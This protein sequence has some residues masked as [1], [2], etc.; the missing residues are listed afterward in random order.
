MP[1]PEP[2]DFDLA[3]QD[4]DRRVAATAP[5][6]WMGAEP[7]YTD[8]RSEAAE[9]LRLADGGDKAARALAM[10]AR[11]AGDSGPAL[12]LRTVGRQYPGEDL[13]RWSFGLYA[14]RDGTPVSAGPPD[15][16]LGGTA[17]S[18]EAL[19]D[20][21]ARLTAELA[22]RG[23]AA[24]SCRCEEV[25]ECRVAFRTDGQP[26]ADLGA[27]P[28]LARPSIHGRAI[29]D[30]GL[31]D[32]LSA[33]GIHLISVGTEPSAT[34]G[35][36]A[37]PRLELPAFATVD[38]FL[39]CLDAIGRAAAGAGLTGLVVAGFPPPVDER[40]AFAT[41]TPDPA[42]VEVNM[43]P[44]ADAAEF[45]AQVRAI[46]RAAAAEGLS[47]VRF[48]YN[49]DVT[50]SGG[51][52]QI[53]FGGPTPETSPFF[54][55]PR[56]LPSLI[57]YCNRHPALSY[58]FT[59][60]CVGSTS[61]SPRPDE[62]YREAFDE[63]RLAL[64]LL[65]LEEDPAPETLWKALA[66]FLTDVAG[67]SHRS[68]INVE[69]LWNPYLLGRGRL[70]LVELRSFRMAPT[71]EALAARAALFRAVVARLAA[72]PDGGEL[73]DWGTELHQRFALPFYLRQ[74]LREVLA[75]LETSGLGLG[76]P[77]VERLLDDG[78]RVLGEAAL[79]DFRLTL[80]R[81]L[82]FWPLAGDAA[83]TTRAAS[84]LIDSST[85]RV[86]AVLRPLDSAAAAA[87]DHWRVGAAGW[88]VPVRRDLDADGQALV[89]SLR[90]RSFI[91][92]QG[93]HPTLGVQTPVEL[94]LHHAGTGAAYRV[95]LHEWK[96]EGGGYE[97]LPED[98]EESRRRR[99]AR[100][101]A[102]PLEPTLAPGFP[103][104]P[105]LAV[106]AYGL[107]LRACGGPAPG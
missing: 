69:K 80:R 92:W 97:G 17:C 94:R 75:D 20:F 48:Q 88:R 77:I 78:D 34:E 33:K 54:L 49:G 41:V 100:V 37:C 57:R 93:L 84:R 50:D 101:V 40:I 51:G 47:A 99:A 81:A 12:L 104:A 9:W 42:V 21:V 6:I 15:P 28:R 46:D 25:P 86:E 3:I 73:V 38:D 61:Q 35:G 13:P 71:P 2:S 67:N 66:P 85:M 45:L 36:G 82:E 103:D 5:P 90:Y 7:T 44:A 89:F 55:R 102:E 19:D 56:L 8:R 23:W 96:P 24:H 18:P 87:L 10:L 16:A 53:T 30:E 22:A 4:H 27:E 72:E 11:L 32:D 39:G 62:R 31:H 76:A 58:Y 64:H 26:A 83:A 68:E 106:N 29:P 63:L 60:T 70:G 98:F 59:P 79:G 91:P 107:D 14:R 65:D 105:S 52:G 95:V 43:A 74:D 1:T